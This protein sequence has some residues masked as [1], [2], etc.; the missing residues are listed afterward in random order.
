MKEDSKA[1]RLNVAITEQ[2]STTGNGRPAAFPSGFPST[3]MNIVLNNSIVGLV[4]WRAIH[5]A[6]LNPEILLHDCLYRVKI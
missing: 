5:T 1:H 4:V 2:T 6:V 3:L